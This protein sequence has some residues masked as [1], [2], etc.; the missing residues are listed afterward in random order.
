M[1][2]FSVIVACLSAAMGIACVLAAPKFRAMFENTE[3]ALPIVLKTS[4]WVPGGVLIVLAG[5]LIALVVA[6]RAKLAG[7]LAVPTFLFLI[8]TAV[9]L[10][11]VLMP[12]LTRLIH[13][14]GTDKK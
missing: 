11:T 8:G 1:R 5:L 2:V 9:V 3:A 12:L 14:V 10:P 4:G 13:R 6:K 7:I